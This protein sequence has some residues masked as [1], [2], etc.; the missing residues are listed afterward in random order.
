MK[1]SIQPPK[2]LPVPDFNQPDDIHPV[3]TA[4]INWNL[5]TFFKKSILLVK[6][7]PKLLILGVALTIFSANSVSSSQTNFQ[8]LIKDDAEETQQEYNV[9]EINLES[10]SSTETIPDLNEAVSADSLTLSAISEYF[11][12][13]EGLMESENYNVDDLNSLGLLDPTQAQNQLTTLLIKS[14]NTL[15]VANRRIQ[16]WVYSFFGLEIY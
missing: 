8:N 15:K 3:S 4:T 7:H 5:I 10:D 6:N 14:S 16:G 1:E 9:N 13:D 11:G 2:P 12:L